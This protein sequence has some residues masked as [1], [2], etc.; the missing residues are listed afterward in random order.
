[1]S[2]GDDVDFMD[3]RNE[4]LQQLIGCDELDK[5]EEGIVK[6]VIDNSPLKHL[7]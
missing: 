2:F 4:F 3:D 7:S 1:M 6:R 5:I